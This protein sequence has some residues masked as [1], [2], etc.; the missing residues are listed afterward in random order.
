VFIVFEGIDGCG[1]TTLSKRFAEIRT[2]IWT[3]EPRFSSEVADRLNLVDKDTISREVEFLLDR[4]RHQQDIGE[5]K[6][7]PDKSGGFRPEPL[8]R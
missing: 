7:P 8:S 5:S 1:K 2:F 4:V 6:L 3:K